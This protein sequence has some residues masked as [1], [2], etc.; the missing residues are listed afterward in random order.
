[1]PINGSHT[2]WILGAGFSKSLGGP[3]LADLFRQEYQNDLKRVLPPELATELTWVQRL[4]NYGRDDEHLWED[5]EDFLAYVED[6]YG[7]DGSRKRSKIESVLR[8]ARYDHGDIST[9]RWLLAGF[10]S[11]CEDPR[12]SVRWALAVECAR[13]LEGVDGDE[14]WGPYLRWAGTLNPELDTV[15]T[16]NYDLVLDRLGGNLEVI[17]PEDVQ[18]VGE[19]YPVYERVPVFKLHGSVDWVGNTSDS[20]VA[21]DGNVL[22]ENTPRAIAAPGRTKNS[23]STGL[24]APL[25]KAAMR[26]FQTASAVVIVGYGFPKTDAEAR[27]KL[28]DAIEG[29]DAGQIK[30]VDLVLGPDDRPETRRVLELVRHRMGVSRRVIVSPRP[31]TL[32]NSAEHV[33]LIT[34]HPL[35]AEDFIGDYLRR[36]KVRSPLRV[37][38]YDAS[39]LS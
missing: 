8:R 36:T 30:Q 16:F 12:R 11:Y 21:L 33:A 29:A 24:F 34:Q 15:I 18:L 10:K 13:F 9:K 17:R 1:M 35:W 14:R 19:R 38:S 7:I 22:K 39:D 31:P 2:V 20:G 25:W 37:V 5:A 26:R 28:L 23:W 32:H 27:M 6:A 4:F 3:L